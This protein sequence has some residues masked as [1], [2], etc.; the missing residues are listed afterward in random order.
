MDE[1]PKTYDYPSP[2]DKLLTYGDPQQY[3]EWP[4]YLAFGFTDEHI[5]DLIRMALDKDLNWADSESLGIWA[6][7]HAWRTLAQLRAEAAAQPLLDLID[8][9]NENDL[10]GNDWLEEELPRIYSMLGT[11][12]IP[13]LTAHVI[14]PTKPLYSRATT[15][16]SLMKMAEDHPETR[17]ECVKAITQALAQFN[18]NEPDLNAFFIGDLMDLK[19]VETTGLVKQAF[20]ADKVDAS[21]AGDFYDFQVELGLIEADPEIEKER[22]RQ[23]EIQMQAFASLRTDQFRAADRDLP[24]QAYIGLDD[25]TLPPSTKR[26]RQAKK[27]AKAKRKQTE[28]MKKLNR[29]KKRR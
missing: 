18:D 21:I 20:D 11:K 2:V 27:K 5:P 28:K 4:D 8:M 3:H 15:S 29:K 17:S 16:H 23:Q 19:A 1:Q 6:P 14:D 7:L 9:F 25:E 26:E 22:A 13:V 10:P 24:A 12:T